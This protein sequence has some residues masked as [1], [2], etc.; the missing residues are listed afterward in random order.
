MKNNNQ[1]IHKILIFIWEFHQ[2][3]FNKKQ[4]IFWMLTEYTLVKISKTILLWPCW[5]S[6]KNIPKI[7]IFI[8]IKSTRDNI[9]F[10][11]WPHVGKR[12]A[13]QLISSQKWLTTLPWPKFFFLFFYSKMIY[14]DINKQCKINVVNKAFGQITLDEGFWFIPVLCRQRYDTS[15]INIDNDCS[16]LKSFLGGS[17]SRHY[18]IIPPHKDCWR[19]FCW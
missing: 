12:L 5:S 7:V 14:N 8:K 11:C 9:F 6:I 16:L 10:G 19:H 18:K 4:H 13:K 17:L 3:T 15:K 1:N 2:N